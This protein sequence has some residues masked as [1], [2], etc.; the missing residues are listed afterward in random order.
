MKK[1]L[2]MLAL[3]ATANAYAISA[4]YEAKIK[5]ELARHNIKAQSFSKEELMSVLTEF[6][7]IVKKNG[8]ESQNNISAEQV[9]MLKQ[10]YGH[11]KTQKIKDPEMQK[12]MNKAIQIIEHSGR[13][14]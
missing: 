6:Q 3:F 12:I 8:Y 11:L 13:M 2:I 4:E 1:I 14:N 5:Q 7:K 9:Q 10:A